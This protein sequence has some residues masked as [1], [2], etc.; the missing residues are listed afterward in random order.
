MTNKRLIILIPVI[1]CAV[2]LF[3]GG[4]FM[5][6]VLATSRSNLMSELDLFNQILNLVGENYVE[7][8]QADS[9]ISGAITGMLDQLDPHTNYIEPERFERMDE[10]NRG[11][12]SGIGISFAIRDGWLTVISPLEGGPSERLGIRPGDIISS[13]DG[14]SAEGIREDEVF[15]KLRGPRGTEVSI[16]VRR[17][18]TEE[19]LPFTI[20]RDD[21]LIQSVP[22]AFMLEPGTGYIRMARFS[23]KT[24][25]E[26]E[27]AL[28][29][30]EALG[31]ERLIL[32]L[33]GNTGGFLNQAISV[34]DKFLSENKTI[35]YTKGRIIGSSEKYYSTRSK[36]PDFPIVVL[37][38]AASASASEIVSG[39]IQDWDRGLVVGNTS[40]GKGLV[41]RQYPLPNDGALL[42]TVARYYT[43]SGR[44]IQRAYTAGNRD[45][46]YAE[47]GE[48]ESPLGADEVLNE[49]NEDE[50]DQN[51]DEA[52]GDISDNPDAD[53]E[54]EAIATDETD[55]LNARPT[56]HTLIQNRKV[57]GGGGITPDIKLD[58]FYQSSRLNTR[59]II[60]R[61]YFDFINEAIGDRRVRWDGSLRSIS[62]NSP[63]T[64]IWLIVSK[65][66]WN[67]IHSRWWQIASRLITT[68]SA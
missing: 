60:D 32:D 54:L 67:P 12:Y 52:T 5:K 65:A 23:A 11:S 61:K 50:P 18:G 59:L 15:D 20:T 46:Y 16:T 57:F 33:R 13:I 4:V 25:D 49:S 30:L 26:L 66:I 44:L 6:D 41:Q 31:M 56:F 53:S 55:S 14:K 48:H 34:S 36:H 38:N 2:T 3:L 10:R 40:F 9:L 43:P 45:D 19:P 39:A 64:M 17:R 62:N 51:G 68:R 42:L 28:G 24:S 29:E 35:V 21:I 22:Y 7:E 63:L 27:A 1:L 47:A 58:N 37:I 8:T